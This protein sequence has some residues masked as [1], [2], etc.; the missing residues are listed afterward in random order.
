MKEGGDAAWWRCG[1]GETAGGGATVV[2]ER[3]LDVAAGQGGAVARRRGG[4]E[5]ERFPCGKFLTILSS[6][7]VSSFRRVWS[8]AEICAGHGRLLEILGDHISSLL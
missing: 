1:G 8:T 6:F 4:E 2:A 7:G 5:G 3:W